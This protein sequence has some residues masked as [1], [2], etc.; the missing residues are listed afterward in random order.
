VIQTK[1]IE[2]LEHK[3]EESCERRDATLG[4]LE[5]VFVKEAGAK[6]PF[7]AIVRTIQCQ[8]IAQQTRKYIPSVNLRG[9]V[10]ALD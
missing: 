3:R 9:N 6:G 2:R 7:T 10:N 1:A 5:S 4:V 8:T